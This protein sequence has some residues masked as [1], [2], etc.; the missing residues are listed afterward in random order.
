MR[1]KVH[2]APLDH[3]QRIL[4]IGCGTGV[5]TRYLS[6]TFPLGTCIGVD[7]SPVPQIQADLPSN[8]SYIQGDVKTLSM[9]DGRLAPGSFDYVFSRLLIFGITDWAAYMRDTVV[10]MLK[11]GG[12][13]EVQDLDY[14]WFKHGHVCSADWKWLRA[15]REGA[16]QKGL[17]L[18]CGS[19]AA[20]YMREVGLTDVSVRRYGVPFGKSSVE[21]RPE[22][23]RI[24]AHW[25]KDLA[26]VFK[27]AIPRLVEP[28]GLEE[29]EV[30]AL[31]EESLECMKPEK[32]KEWF[33]HVTVGRR[34][35]A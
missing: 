20:K 18:D 23:R 1:H 35:Q 9:V 5:V 26:L 8:I 33:M 16:R 4:D 28:L 24:A 11:P 32:G 14:V 25:V 30:W 31:V 19:N 15:I 13:A 12:W 22:T 2:H 34:P 21:A 3:P 6:T 10:P 7:L 29:A 27:P 17:D